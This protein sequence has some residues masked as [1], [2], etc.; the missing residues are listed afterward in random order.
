MKSKTT[1]PSSSVPGFAF[2]RGA[3]DRRRR[4]PFKKTEH[5]VRGRVNGEGD[6]YFS[7]TTFS[8]R[9]YRRPMLTDTRRSR[10]FAMCLIVSLGACRTGSQTPTPEVSLDGRVNVVLVDDEATAALAILEKRHAN[11][12]VSEAD[13]RKLFS[14]EG[15]RRL[16]EREASL[17]RAF[18]DSA[19]RAFILSD[20]LVG[21]TPSLRSTLAGMQRADVSDA[22]RR[23]LVSACKRAHRSPTLSGDK[24]GDCCLGSMR[25]LPLR[26]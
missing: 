14:A 18:T 2:G 24:T 12:P 13:W 6:S 7:S 25:R 10:G 19:F 20:T 3:P 17:Q 26:Y 9:T 11:Q 15:Y 8:L 1:S 23:A 21:R 16:K 5:C 4:A 22:A